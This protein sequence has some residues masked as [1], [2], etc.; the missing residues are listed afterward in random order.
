VSDWI[1]HFVQYRAEGDISHDNPGLKTRRNSCFAGRRTASLACRRS[2]TKLFV[3][4]RLPPGLAALLFAAPPEDTE[5]TATV[6][7][8]LYER[9]QSRGLTI[10]ALE[11]VDEQLD[12]FDKL[13]PAQAVARLTQSLDDF[14]AGYPQLGKLLEAYVAG[15]ERRIAETV[16]EDF[17]DPSVRDL[18]DPLL[19]HRN[20]IMA[21]RAETYLR[22]GGAFAAVGA[23]HLVGPRSII[24]ILRAQGFK[25]SRVQ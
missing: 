16:A 3:L 20:Q 12:L 8:R 4:H 25:I 14:E 6:D 7:G 19:S 18:A 10:A 13:A 24:A 23:A 15:D 11:T 9:S 21:A 22:R 5:I 2:S 1:L 17:K